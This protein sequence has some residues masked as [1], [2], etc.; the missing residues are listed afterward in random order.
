MTIYKLSFILVFFSILIKLTA[1]H[2]TNFDLFGDE[3]QYWLWSRNIEFGYYSKPPMLPWFIA[4]H[5]FLFGNE[6]VSLKYLPLIFYFFTSYVVFLLSCELYQNKKLAVTSALTFY[7]LPSVGVSSFLI[8]TDV[9]LVFFCS[10]VLLF[11]LKIREKPSIKNFL[12]LGFFLGC[13][14]L[15]KYAAIYYVLSII[16]I[17]FLDKKLRLAFVFNP[18]G[19]LVFLVFFTLTLMPNI[20]WNLNNDWVTFLHTSDNAGLDRANFN[21]KRGLIFLLTQTF[22]LC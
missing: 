20:L 5:G 21:L 12:I 15:S 2:F 8:S 16:I 9:I 11:I 6:F 1:I 17:I 10:L 18:L 4:I 3:A 13:S 7:L 14:F 22:M 19:V